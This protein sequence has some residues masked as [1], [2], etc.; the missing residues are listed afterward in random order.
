MANIVHFI[1][2]APCVAETAM[3]G[4]SGVTIDYNNW[5]WETIDDTVRLTEIHYCAMY[6][7]TELQHFRGFV[8]TY[9]SD[10]GIKTQLFGRVDAPGDFCETIA[11]TEEVMYAEIFSDTND[12]EGWIFTGYLGSIF[13]FRANGNDSSP[14][15][16]LGGPPIGFKVNEG[17][18]QGVAVYADDYCL[19]MAIV[20]N[21]C[22]C[23]A[24]SFL[25][26]TTAPANMETTAV[27]GPIVVNPLPY[28]DN[29]MEYI[30]DQDCG[31]YSVTLEPEYPFLSI[32]T[33]GTVGPSQWAHQYPDQITVSSNDVDDIGKYSVTLR[34][35]Q[36]I[37][38]GDGYTNPV[39]GKMDDLTKEFEVTVNPC[40]ETLTAGTLVNDMTYTIGD[41]TMQ[42]S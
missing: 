29:K 3:Y 11:I 31:T 35:S 36:V 32:Q 7:G 18:A 42:S 38:N 5:Q 34:I 14:T 26:T 22:N 12:I 8:A 41:S 21:G 23:P 33:T 2:A 1:H 27:T 17:Y 30:Y 24:S 15:F 9:D 28:Y 25:D 6:Y 37:A 19:Q 39:I 4:P 10:S 16:R 40:L 13:T 20:Y